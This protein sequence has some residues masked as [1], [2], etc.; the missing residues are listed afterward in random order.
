MKSNIAFHGTKMITKV[1]LIE[2]YTIEN[3]S[4][5][6]SKKIKFYNFSVFSIFCVL[7]SHL[8]KCYT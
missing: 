1:M 3:H 7:Y 5:K 2:V 6:K 8:V 4:D